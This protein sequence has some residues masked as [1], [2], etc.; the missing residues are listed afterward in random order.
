MTNFA[1][2][3]LSG[4]SGVNCV[5]WIRGHVNDYNLW[6]G[7][8]GDPRWSYEGLSPYF[9]RVEHYHDSGADARHHG[10]HGPMHTIAVLSRRYP[11]G[12]AVH[13]A[14]VEVG[15]TENPDFHDGDPLGLGNWTE[16]W[17]AGSCQPAGT[18][19]SL[20]RVRA[21]TNAVVQKVLIEDDGNDKNVA[22]G[23][24]L[25][26][27]RQFSAKNEMIVSSV[28]HKTLQVLMLSGIGPSEEL[29]RIGIEQMVESPHVGQN[30]L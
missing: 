21:V 10:F 30:F 17:R 23:V 9:R 2:K 28:T 26:D 5:A 22:T 25:V 27:G 4:S 7:E 18:V 19:F 6:P 20:T 12:K 14:F 8:V 3:M 16:N 13:D 29:A 15:Y 11:L 1:D 24:Q